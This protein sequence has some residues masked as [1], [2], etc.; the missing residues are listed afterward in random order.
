MNF[1]QD[2]MAMIFPECC[3]ACN[4]GLAKNEHLVCLS[5]QLAM[6]HT[7]FHLD[8]KNPLAQRFWG[9]VPLSHASAFYKFT[10][11]S[12][13]QSLL[14]QLKYRN[15]PEI[16]RLLAYWY[17]Q[18]LLNTGFQQ[19]FDL[20]IPVPLHPAKLR[21]RGYNQ[22]D[23]IALGL[24]DALDIPWAGSVVRRITNTDTQTR[25]QRLER[26][27]NVKGVFAVADT[28]L[29]RQQR[30]LLV[31]DVITTGATLE[32]CASLLLECGCSE[33]GVASIAVA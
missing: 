5:C 4:D 2:F 28:S 29:L 33:V 32:V 10:K 24:S 26:F 30:V 18:E 17:G 22:A 20:I 16:G 27:E 11:Q 8:E 19:K 7:H 15:Q 6:P 9:K 21:K 23:S 25:K 3:L 1:V 12:R 13:V 31:D 14:H